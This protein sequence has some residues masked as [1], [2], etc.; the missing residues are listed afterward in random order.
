MKTLNKKGGGVGKN[1]NNLVSVSNHH[2]TIVVCLY[3]IGDTF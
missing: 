3:I 2:Q 1:K